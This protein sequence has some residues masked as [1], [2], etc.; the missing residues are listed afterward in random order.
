MSGSFTG[1]G[2]WSEAQ[3]AEYQAGWTRFIDMPRRGQIITT[4]KG[5]AMTDGGLRPVSVYTRPGLYPGPAVLAAAAQNAG[6]SQKV[7]C[8]VVTDVKDV[9]WMP[10]ELQVIVAIAGAESSGNC[11]AYHANTSDGSMDHGPWQIN[12]HAHPGFFTGPG[13]YLTAYNP[14][15]AAAMARV[16]YLDAGKAF[17]P[18]MGYSGPGSPWL[19][20]RDQGKGETWLTWASHGVATLNT[21]LAAGQ[22]LR[23]IASV[24]LDEPA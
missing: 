8:P 2:D 6:F 20:W 15:D 9:R 17:T 4:W 12:D 5:N 13:Q 24:D 16:I 22:D 23:T 14:W 1:P 19:G 18:W 7:T 3:I 21:M 10:S 11:W